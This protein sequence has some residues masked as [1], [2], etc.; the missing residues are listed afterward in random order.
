MIR[1]ACV[2]LAG[3]TFT[4]VLDWYRVPLLDLSEWGE[5]VGNRE[6]AVKGKR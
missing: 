6:K 1:S 3:A 5:I 4:S 2:N